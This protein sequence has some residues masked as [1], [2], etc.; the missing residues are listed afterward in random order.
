M[1]HRNS[2]TCSVIVIIIIIVKK[3]TEARRLCFRSSSFCL[4]QTSTKRR[5]LISFICFCLLSKR[6]CDCAVI[7]V[8]KHTEVPYFVFVSCTKP[9]FCVRET[10][11]VVGL[12]L[13][14]FNKI[15]NNLKL[16]L[17]LFHLLKRFLVNSCHSILLFL[18]G[19]TVI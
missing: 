1:K 3:K 6:I 7:L 12:A 5:F 16:H 2:H 9:V 19:F 15:I 13:R 18:C 8:I 17:F 10:V 4:M 14:E 11:F